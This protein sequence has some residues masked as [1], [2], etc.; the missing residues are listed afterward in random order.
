MYRQGDVVL[1]KM[2][3]SSGIELKKFRPGIIIQHYSQRDFIT[4]I[5]LSS[6]VNK[7]STAEIL[8]TP[9][10]NNG[11]EKPSLA[12]CWYIQTVGAKRIQKSIGNLSFADYKSVSAI[13]K[14][15]L[16]L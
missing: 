5:P 12:L 3:P 13:T 7:I 15:Y 11:L 6:Q 9:S 14:K 4:F 2:H 10:K 8:I 16:K 1:I